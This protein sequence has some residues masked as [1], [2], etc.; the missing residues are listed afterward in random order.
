VVNDLKQNEK[1]PK[2]DQESSNCGSNRPVS[3]VL[4]SLAAAPSLLVRH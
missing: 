4:L 1:S 2:S 3:A